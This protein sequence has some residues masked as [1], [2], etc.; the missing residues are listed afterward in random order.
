MSFIPILKIYDQLSRTSGP[1]SEIIEQ[2]AKDIAD[3]QPAETVKRRAYAQI[4]AVLEKDLPALIGQPRT[5]GEA[6]AGT[7]ASEA[8]GSVPPAAGRGLSS[9]E[10]VS[11]AAVGGSVRGRTSGADRGGSGGAG[12][13]VGLERV[14]SARNPAVRTKSRR[15]RTV[16]AGGDRG[17]AETAAPPPE[18]GNRGAAPESARR[19]E[20]VRA[21]ELAAQPQSAAETRERTETAAPVAPQ[22]ATAASGETAAAPRTSSE[23]Q[24][25]AAAAGERNRAATPSPERIEQRF[26]TVGNPPQ[27]STEKVPQPTES[28]FIV[29]SS[30]EIKRERHSLK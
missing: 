14:R 21:T 22:P 1:I 6:R 16:E 7:G 2:A 27:V 10:G 12:G 19:E 23:Q 17:E 4:R 9:G 30:S 5:S 18:G 25:P 8:G 3:G 20:A 13:D 11:A 26:V 24:R 29:F 28:H 15:V